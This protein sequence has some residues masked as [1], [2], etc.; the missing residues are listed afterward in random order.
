MKSEKGKVKRERNE[1]IE[2]KWKDSYKFDRNF[3]VDPDALRS[4]FAVQGQEA[5]A[6]GFGIPERVC[7]GGMGGA[8]GLEMLHVLHLDHKDGPGFKAL[9]HTGRETAQVLHAPLGG[10]VGEADHARFLQGDA[11]DLGKNAAAALLQVEIKAGIPVDVLGANEIGHKARPAGGEPFP[12]YGVGSGGVHVDETLAFF[13]GNQVPPRLALRILRLLDIDRGAGDQ[14][15][16]AAAGVL[17]MADG[18]FPIQLDMGDKAIGP[19]EE[20]GLAGMFS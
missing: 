20:D 17:H 16:P 6:G 2:Q 11:L 7:E 9:C 13:H 4:H 18:I 12:K 19:G 14:Q 8:I 1:R 15:L 5:D 10:G 3:A